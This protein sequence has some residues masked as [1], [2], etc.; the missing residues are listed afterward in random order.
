MSTYATYEIKLDIDRDNT[1]DHAN[2]NITG[3][4]LAASWVNGMLDSY[5]QVGSP[6]R[7]NLTLDNSS[8]DFSQDDAGATYYGK[9]SRGM[10]VR[11]RVTD[12]VGPTTHTMCI[13]KITKLGYQSGSFT[14][15]K[16]TILCEDEM[17][18]MLA[19]EY[20]PPLQTNTS[21]DV[22]LT[23]IFASGIF[24]YPYA[25]SYWCLGVP[26]ASE[27]GQKTTLLDHTTFI[28]FDTG[29]STFSYIGD[30][31]GGGAT[32]AN[33]VIRD[34]LLAEDGRFFW[35]CRTSKAV[36]Q[37]RHAD[38]GKTS[39]SYTLNQAS[40]LSA[41]YITDDDVINHLTIHYEPRAVG[42]A[43]SVLWSSD[44]VPITIKAGEK[45]S[46]RARFR[47]PDHPGSRVAAETVLPLSS[48]IDYAVNSVSDGSG[49]DKK[50]SV[51]VGMSND[52]QSADISIKNYGST[53]VYVTLLQVRG[54]PLTRYE[55]ASV[56]AIDGVSIGNYDHRF[57]E[58]TVRLLDSEA[59]A[60]SYADYMLTRFKDPET[61]FRKVT[62]SANHTAALLTQALT[63]QI[64]DRITVADSHIGHSQDYIIVGEEHQVKNQRLHT[65]S[66]ILKPYSRAVGWMLGIA[67]KSELGETTYVV[68]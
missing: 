11:V 62:F 14:E 65:T 61:R 48:A 25:K 47:D 33:S 66:W 53:A 46:V 27:L 5:D 44:S 16:L 29:V 26:G 4:V 3:Y 23:D 24:G 31:T 63:R 42:A 40:I 59:K 52:A 36:F 54:T 13:L 8:G 30:N 18:N 51:S 68:Y 58:I 6:S 67:G 56:K 9:L 17:T 12:P 41:Q 35:D 55:A 20:Q 43:G 38:L 15:R 45:R 21:V 1:F 10:L 28:N 22:A 50:G 64:G 37:N 49:T 39:S 19:R 57:N 60:Q 34:L 7:L 32:N 2:D